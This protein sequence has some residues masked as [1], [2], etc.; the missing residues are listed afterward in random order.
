VLG[1][2]VNT[3]HES[4]LIRFTCWEFNVR[5]FIPR[6]LPDCVGVHVVWGFDLWYFTAMLRWCSRLLIDGHNYNQ[7]H[8]TRDRVIIFRC[9]STVVLQLYI[10]SIYRCCGNVVPYKWKVHNEKI[11]V[12]SFVVK[13]S[14]LSISRWRSR[15]EADLVYLWYPLCQAQWDRCDQQNHETVNYKGKEICINRERETNG[16]G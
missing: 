13:F 6:L 2:S 11:E 10:Y 3:W 12:I 5:Q 8:H 9:T 14:S 16:S 15:Y 7:S 4:A 1:D